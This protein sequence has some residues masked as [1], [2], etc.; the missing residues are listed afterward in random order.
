MPRGVG[1]KWSPE[2]RAKYM[3]TIRAKAASAPQW[4]AVNTLDGVSVFNPAFAEALDVQIERLQ[5]VRDLLR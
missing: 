4:R 5:K 2:H 3:A 1:K